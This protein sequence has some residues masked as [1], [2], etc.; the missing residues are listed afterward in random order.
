MVH[1]T[2]L[3]QEALVARAAA[4]RGAITAEREEYERFE[5]ALLL[6]LEETV[7]VLAAIHPVYRHQWQWQRQRQ[8]S[9]RGLERGRGEGPA[10]VLSLP[11]R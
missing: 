7:R 2:T 10:A 4:V 9:W 5:E 11:H 3:Y 6:T 8:R 1:C